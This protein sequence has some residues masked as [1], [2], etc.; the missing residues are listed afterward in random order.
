VST[1]ASRRWAGTHRSFLASLAFLTLTIPSFLFAAD[2]LA[3]LESVAAAEKRVQP[4]LQ[5]YLVTVETT[6]DEETEAHLTENLPPEVKPPLPPVI[7]KFWQRKGGGLVYA[8]NTQMAP[9]VEKMVRQISADLS[10]ELN[11]VLLPPERAGQRRDLVKGA[12]ITMSD[13]ALTDKL[14]HHLEIMFAQPTNLDQAFYANV[15]HLPQKQIKTLVFDVDGTSGTVNELGIVTDDNLQLIV[16]IRY[17]EV[18][19]CHIPERFKVTSP[20][21]KVDDL[22]EIQFTNVDGFRLPSR[23]L[24]TLRRPDL[25][26]NLEVLFKNYRINQQISLDIQDRL[27]GK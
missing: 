3:I 4:E 6:L 1:S 18:P 2:D 8:S 16:E 5:N 20:D 15:L 10:S 12:K 7:N 27:N 22:L 13:V 9:D 14:I 17:I 26:E 25:Q 23:M 21:G 24:H 19:D 11:E